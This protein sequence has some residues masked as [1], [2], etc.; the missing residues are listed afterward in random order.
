MDKVNNNGLQVE[1][2]INYFQQTCVHSYFP[3]RIPLFYVSIA[4]LIDI[5]I[6]IYMFDMK[7]SIWNTT[8][9][10]AILIKL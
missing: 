5:Q 9:S 7:L 10:L 2:G 8:K 3:L 1:H 4:T 6:N